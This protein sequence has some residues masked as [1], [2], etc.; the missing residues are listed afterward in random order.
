MSHLW[1]HQRTLNLSKIMMQIEKT[2]N[3]VTI[4]QILSEIKMKKLTLLNESDNFKSRMN[5]K[6]V[7]K[8]VKKNLLSIMTTQNI[9]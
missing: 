1:S 4:K 3:S 9:S 7:Q 5:Q 6:Q 2:E 8:K